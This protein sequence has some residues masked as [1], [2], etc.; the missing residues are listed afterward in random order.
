M[1]RIPQIARFAHFKIFCMTIIRL[2]RTR[3][4]TQVIYFI[5]FVN[6]G[7]R[8]EM[9]KKNSPKFDN[10]NVYIFSKIKYQHRLYQ[11]HFSDMY[12]VTSF[13]KTY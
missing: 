5:S 7:V 8:A 1:F 9:Y 4:E 2:S 12:F 13:A 6:I 11:F 3:D 10:K